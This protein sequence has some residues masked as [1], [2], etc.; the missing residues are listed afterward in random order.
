[1]SD[2]RFYHLTRTT[3]E[4]ALPQMLEKTLERRQRAVVMAS[5]EERVE[6]LNAW[7]WTYNDRSFLPHGS[8]RDGHGA[9]QPIWLTARDETPNG[10]Q[11][12]FLTDG[13]TCARLGDYA[14]CAVLFD[15]NDPAAVAAAREQWRALRD[16]GHELT[17]WQQD[18]RGRWAEKT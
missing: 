17:Y 2:I 3:L 6:A 18:E 13:A 16:T 7:L 4:R 11:V 10:A 8:A 1:M 9:H 14:R 12:L 5:S 15:G